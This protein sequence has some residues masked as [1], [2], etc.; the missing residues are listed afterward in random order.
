MWLTVAIVR[1]TVVVARCPALHQ[2]HTHTPRLLAQRPELKSWLLQLCCCCCAAAVNVLILWQHTRNA[3]ILPGTYTTAQAYACARKHRLCDCHK[4]E[5]SQRGCCCAV[6]ATKAEPGW[7]CEM[8]QHSSSSS[9]SSRA[10]NSTRWR[11]STIEE[12][13]R[14]SF[15][16]STLFVYFPHNGAAGRP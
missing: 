7:P 9:S 5:S 3:L 1:K 11:N 16:Q 12:P 14:S 10:R 6:T 15:C 8:R 2:P 13:T 4:G